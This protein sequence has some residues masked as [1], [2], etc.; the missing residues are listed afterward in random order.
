MV[1]ELRSGTLTRP[2][3]QDE[4]SALVKFLQAKGKLNLLVS[5]GWDCDLEVEHLY[6]ENLLPLSELLA[7]LSRSEE[8]GIFRLGENDLLIESADR[9]IVF[10]LCHESD[11]HMTTKEIGM[12]NEIQSSWASKNYS[13]Y[14]VS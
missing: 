12:A 13:L 3:L 6:Q 11:I 7:F 5:Y 10:T 14:E 1:T 8:A 9:S 4:V 2:Q